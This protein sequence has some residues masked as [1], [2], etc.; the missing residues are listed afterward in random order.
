MEIVHVAFEL[1]SALLIL[2]N[3]LQNSE[4]PAVYSH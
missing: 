3:C 4:I 1:L 2:V